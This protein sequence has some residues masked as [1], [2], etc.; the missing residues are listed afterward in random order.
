MAEASAAELERARAAVTVAVQ[1]LQLLRAEVLRVVP[2]R[3]RG[4]REIVQTIDQALRETGLAI[5]GVGDDAPKMWRRALDAA[6]R[7]VER[8]ARFIVDVHREAA[9][10]LARLWRVTVTEARAAKEA[11]AGAVRT[12]YEAA[13]TAVVAAATILTGLI[14]ASGVVMFSGWVVLALIVLLYFGMKD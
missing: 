5:Q 7:A 12:A 14:A 2:E 1:S 8:T 4:R 6:Q 9:E 10:A 13:K 11:V 3:S